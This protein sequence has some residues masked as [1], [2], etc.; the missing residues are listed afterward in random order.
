MKNMY[1]IRMLCKVVNLHHS[2][3]Y[4]H[5]QNRKNSYKT[6]NIELDKNSENN[7]LSDSDTLLEELE[8]V[9]DDEIL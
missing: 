6:A 5:K 7:G 9:E 8:E 2:V 4:Y 3:Y 1:D